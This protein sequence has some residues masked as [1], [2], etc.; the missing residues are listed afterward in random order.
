M[1]FH[2][3]HASAD[4]EAMVIVAEDTDVFILCL[5]MFRQL[6]GKIYIRCGTKNRLRHIDISKVG[7]SLGKDTCMALSGLHAFTGRDSVN[8][9]SGRGKVV[10]LKNVMKG[11]R[12]QEAM[13][14]LGEN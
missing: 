14:G 8:A 4:Y 3:K 1:L 11:G 5:A 2:A 12:L 7:Q 10:A 13:E 6:S 9:F